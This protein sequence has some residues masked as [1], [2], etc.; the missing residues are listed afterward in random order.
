MSDR[1]PDD[2]QRLGSGLNV[3]ERIVK[4]QLRW[5]FINVGSWVRYCLP[6][7]LTAMSAAVKGF[8]CRPSRLL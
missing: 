4:S 6:G 8:G 7:H 3:I 1:D 2:H 5:S